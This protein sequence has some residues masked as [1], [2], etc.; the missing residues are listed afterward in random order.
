M[1]N[2]KNRLLGICKFCYQEIFGTHANKFQAHQK[3]CK[4]NPDRNKAVNQLKNAANNRYIKDT[5]TC[6]KSCVQNKTHKYSFKRIDKYG[7]F[8]DFCI[9]LSNGILV[10]LEIDGKQHETM[11]QRIH[12]VIR[13]SRIRKLGYIIYR[14][15]WNAIN[16]S[17]GK[18]IMENKIKNFL[19]W[20][21]TL[22]NLV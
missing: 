8:L 18:I 2:N 21:K 22:N 11:K 3:W 16:T 20:F 14:I 19:Q 12:D 6:S 1:I 9:K 10:D 15:K 17:Q 7:Y 5:D 4:A 13:D